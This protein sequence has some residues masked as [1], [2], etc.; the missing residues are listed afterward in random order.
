MNNL[1]IINASKYATSNDLKCIV[2]QCMDNTFHVSV[3]H[4]DITYMEMLDTPQNQE[5][6]NNQI[7][8]VEAELISSKLFSEKNIDMKIKNTIDRENALSSVPSGWNK[9][10]NEFYDKLDSL[11][12]KP[13]INK[14]GKR[15]G[16]MRIYTYPYIEEFEK[17]IIDTEKASYHT[18]EV[19]GNLGSLRDGIILDVLCDEHASDRRILEP[20]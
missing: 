8:H 13:Q 9:L 7:E 17:T 16:S 14:V 10:I 1:G 2:Y 18:C 4:E 12:N 11:E 5:D 20:Y 6:F 15:F 3:S 19:C